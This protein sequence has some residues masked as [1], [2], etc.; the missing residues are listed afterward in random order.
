MSF[1]TCPLKNKICPFGSEYRGAGICGRVGIPYSYLDI[2]PLNASARQK[3]K[4]K[5]KF[6]NG[7]ADQEF[8]KHDRNHR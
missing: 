3:K 4:M 5:D 2:C 6:Y 8:F 7:M 1:M